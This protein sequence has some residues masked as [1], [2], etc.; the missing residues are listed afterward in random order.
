M[1]RHIR[2]RHRTIRD[3]FKADTMP[4]RRVIGKYASRVIF[5]CSMGII[6]LLVIPAGLLFL[7]IGGI[8]KAVDWI[9]VKLDPDDG[10]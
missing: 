3:N 2:K 10:Q 6:G 9:T 4:P 5:G 1:N 7:S 8:W